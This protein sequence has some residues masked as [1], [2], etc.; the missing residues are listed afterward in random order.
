[1]VRYDPAH[2]NIQIG[3][4]V[5][6]NIVVGNNNF[7]VNTNHGTIVYQQAAPQVRARDFTSKPPRAIRGFLNRATELQTLE[8]WI[9]ANETILIHGPDGIGKSSLI[10]QIANGNAGRA[11]PH[12]VIFLEGAS[13]KEEV[14]GP[15]D[16][17]QR[18][19]DALFES[20]P[21]LKVDVNTARP[22]LSNTRPLLLFD[23]VAL[24]P[25]LQSCLPDLFPNG[26]MIFTAD[27]VAGREDFLRLPI[28]PLQRDIAIRLL[29]NKSG[30][31][32]H[33]QNSSTLNVLCG[34]L[35]DISLAVVITSNVIRETGATLEETLAYMQKIARFSHD[36]LDRAFAFAFS[37]LKPAEREILSAAAF[38]PGMSMSPEWLVA[39]CGSPEAEHCIE[40]LK[41]LGLLAANSPRLRLPPG[42]RIP[43]Q[44][45]SILEEDTVLRRLSVFLLANLELN[46]Q[47]WG[48]FAN[49]LGN[50]FGALGW[51]IRT[52]HWTQ[53]IQLGLALD[54]YLILRGYWDSWRDL[55]DGLLNAARQSGNRAS[56]AFVL[57][58]LGTR[59]IGLG[60]RQLALDYLYQALQLRTELGDTLGMAYTQ[61]N[62]D[63]LVGPPPPGD[64]QPEPQ[65]PSPP[66]DAGLLPLVTG[67][68]GFLVILA[69]V[70]LT[71]L[72]RIIPTPPP[73]PSPIFVLTDTPT[74][75]P[76]GT[77]TNL[78]TVTATMTLTNMPTATPVTPTLTPVIPILGIDLAYSSVL[79]V[80]FLYQG[81]NTDYF[82]I[83]VTI[84]LSNSTTTTIGAFNL[85]ILYQAYDGTHTARFRFDDQVNYSD[86]QTLGGVAAGDVLNEELRIVIPRAYQDSELNLFARVDRC[87]IDIQCTPNNLSY[88]LPLVIYDFVDQY[89]NAYWP[90]ATQTPAGLVG[91][92]QSPIL[93][94]NSQPEY[95]LYT[96]PS[97]GAGSIEGYFS[98]VYF[99][100]V[101]PIQGDVLLV[102]AGFLAQAGGDGVTFRVG[103]DGGRGL[104]P[105]QVV[106]FGRQVGDFGDLV[107]IND[108]NDGI[109]RNAV[110]ILPDQNEGRCSGFYLRVD[111][112]A[113]TDSDWAYWVSAYIARF[114]TNSLPRP[115]AT[116][117]SSPFPPFVTSCQTSSQASGILKLDITASPQTYIGVNQIIEYK[118]ILT[119]TGTTPLGPAQFT[120]TDNKLGAPF[121]CGHA[122]ATLA[123]NQNLTC[124]MDYSIGASDMRSANIIHN[125][126]ASGAGQTS[127]PATCTVTNLDPRLT[128]TR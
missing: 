45:A 50:F 51:A 84:S 52:N 80:A 27:I 40:R 93:E 73:A 24:S 18:L 15:N 72:Q 74:Y 108:R 14:L 34:L 111:A 122:N 37:R 19:F 102:R 85:S 70:A 47:N 86:L 118:Y 123:A 92:V 20:V 46:S 62:I 53:A 6:G 106:S 75:T 107:V 17:V 76:T 121:P 101:R 128:P 55:L 26:A 7:V 32:R 68:F 38:T 2:V 29:V 5:D 16:V 4:N 71:F 94:G 117:T 60:T 127:A 103:C 9:L 43:A 1:M 114:R 10:R 12:G 21:L 13:I 79:E 58:Q 59:A 69:I 97:P 22:Y 42:L 91:I 119:N 77:A 63:F 104:R 113:T 31:A 115:P 57:H 116:S 64:G 90:D 48:F 100:E 88:S 126:T 61:H 49:E 8:G 120:I 33:P 35:G 105:A 125:A 36:G 82:E 87:Q 112:G 65:P 81:L 98:D 99:G 39:V 83:P 96:Y 23:E 54:P 30:L 44:R 11:M 25:T 66:A 67:G 110:A 56:E 3:G 109:L 124:S 28:G 78:P 41:A 89:Q 95:A